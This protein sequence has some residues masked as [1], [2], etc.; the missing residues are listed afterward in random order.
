MVVCGVAQNKTTCQRSVRGAQL[1]PFFLCLTLPHLLLNE[2]ALQTGEART[3]DVRP[4]QDI[5]VLEKGTQKSNK[6]VEIPIFIAETLPPLLF[7]SDLWMDCLRDFF[8]HYFHCGA[9]ALT[10]SVPFI[11]V[12]IPF[13][14]AYLSA[15]FAKNG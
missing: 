8:S 1:T 4:L 9:A 6:E 13:T 3:T 12:I 7:V 5:C 11:P 10:S 14:Y 15:V 2:S